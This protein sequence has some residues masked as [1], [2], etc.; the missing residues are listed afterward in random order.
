MRNATASRP[1]FG[2]AAV[3]NWIAHGG[4]TP[5]SV[6]P[7]QEERRRSVYLLVGGAPDGR[8]VVAKR[9]PRSEAEREQI[10]YATLTSHRPGLSVELYGVADADTDRTWLFLQAAAGRQ[11]RLGDRRDRA[12][13]GRWLGELHVACADLPGGPSLRDRG[14]DHFREYLDV[15]PQRATLAS[16]NPELDAGDRRDVARTVEVCARVRSQWDEVSAFCAT[17]PPT[18]VFGDFKDDN[19]RV[20]DGAGGPT[21]IGFDWNEAGWGVP[22]LDVLTF[23]AHRT[24][25]LLSE[26]LPIVSARWPEMT[27]ERIRL[28]GVVG[29]IFRCGA[30]M[31][32]E[33]QRLEWPW[34][35]TAMA[36]L[37]YHNDWMDRCIQAVQWLR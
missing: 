22:A 6:V 24:A 37:R 27:A 34:T 16:A 31:R 26:Y 11:F 17:M 36:R 5:T 14:P 3:E 1:T 9:C 15:V 4:S 35:Q 7:L 29:E 12:V 2:A 20:V 25:P 30:S 21:L 28:L 33:L 8:D 13:A 10:V 23:E 19:V 18:F 32:W